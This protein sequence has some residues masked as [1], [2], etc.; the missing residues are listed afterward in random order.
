MKKINIIILLPS[1]VASGPIKGAFA[2]ANNLVDIGKVSLIFIKKGNKINDYLDPKIKKIYLKGNSFNLFK[3]IIELR[4]NLRN[5]KR[6]NLIT[7]SFCFSADLLNI[8]CKD[9]SNSIS[10]VRGNLFKN[11]YFDYGLKGKIAAL[12]HILILNFIDIVIAMSYDMKKQLDKYLIKETIIIPNFINE[13]QIKPYFKSFISN[14]DIFRFIFIGNLNSRKKTLLIIKAIEKLNNR[15]KTTLDIIGNGQ[16]ITE[17]KK[18]TNKKNLKKVI[19][20]HGQKEKPFDLLSKADVFVLP[21]ESEGISR[22][23]LEALYLG[24]P[25]VIRGVDSNHLLLENSNSGALFDKDEDLADIMIRV[26][27]L[28]K[29]RS[30]RECLLPEKFREHNAKEKFKQ[31]I[32]QFLNYKN[33]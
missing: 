1:E 29:E 4:N 9:L 23:S 18:Y 12:F 21:S 10:S 28:S 16:Q 19:F 15:F 27:I 6:E 22:A 5:Y 32:N 13:S 11:Y 33:E 8:F 14:D 17:L 7:I 25:I 30:T 26:A 2:L 20:F 3:K 31:I 24:I